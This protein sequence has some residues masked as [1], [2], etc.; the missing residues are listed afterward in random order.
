MNE[1]VIKDIENRIQKHKYGECIYHYTSIPVLYN[2]LK[3]K[4]FWLGSTA[5]MNDSKE[6][7]Y[8][9]ELIRDELRKEIY[10]KISSDKLNQFDAFFDNV[11]KRIDKEYPYAMC[12]SKLKD[13]AAQWERYADGGKGVCIVLNTRKFM[14]IFYE[15]HILFN[16]VYYDFDVKKHSHYRVLYDYFTTGQLRDFSDEKGQVDN[17]I[18]CGY[19]H[20][21]RSFTSEQEIRM[22]NLWNHIP[23]YAKVKTECISG[24]IKRV[25]KIDVEK[26]CVEAGVSFEDIFE[27]IIIGPKSRQDIFSLKSYIEECGYIDL[28]D[29]VSKSDCP[30]R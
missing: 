27:G 23:K 14:R 17:A 11:I 19:V 7:K 24:I 28:K 13:D 9:I 5:T 15:T 4:E 2:I 3:N 6:V 18:A 16:N 29:K 25:M 21:H 10:T 12:F 26:R 30:L 1:L 20:K 22:V 8:F